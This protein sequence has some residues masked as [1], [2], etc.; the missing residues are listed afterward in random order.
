MSF[1]TTGKSTIL[2][3]GGATGIGLSFTARLLALG[4]TVIAVGRRLD[5]LNEAKISYPKLEIIQGDIGSDTGR[6]ALHE[7]ALRL[8]PDI[9]VLFNNAASLNMTPA[10]K[11]SGEQDW[12]SHKQMIDTNVNGM[13]HM[14]VLF[15]PHLLSKQNALIANTTS[16]LGFVPIAMV[17]TYCATKGN[18]HYCHFLGVNYILND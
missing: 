16:F 5:I 6:V 8:F 18:Y 1:L 10:L 3:T 2:I 13:V 12:E 7:K 4:H 9:N 11:D 17:P 15:L 14:S